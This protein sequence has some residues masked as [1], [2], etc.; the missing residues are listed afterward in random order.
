M[1]DQVPPDSQ[2]GADGVSP[3]V[4]DWNLTSG[5]VRESPYLGLGPSRQPQAPLAVSK[6]VMDQPVKV[7]IQETY[8][9]SEVNASCFDGTERC[10]RPG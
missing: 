9:C 5:D 10:A 3:L 2:P 8:L 1:F 7:T 4:I 6:T